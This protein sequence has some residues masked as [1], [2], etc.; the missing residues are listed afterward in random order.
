MKRRELIGLFG[1]AALAWPLAARGQRTGK[2][3]RVGLI[4]ST[5][6]VASMIGADPRNTAA[7]AFVH[8]LLCLASQS[9]TPPRSP[10]ARAPR[11]AE[12]PPPTSGLPPRSP[13]RRWHGLRPPEP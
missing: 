7:R 6:P 2:I 8:A 4:L 13:V 9:R 11:E 5:S 10:R 12:A 3:H 1:A